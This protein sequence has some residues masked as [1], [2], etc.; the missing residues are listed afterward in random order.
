VGGIFALLEHQ[1]ALYFPAGN[2][3]YK[4][5]YYNYFTEIEEHFVRR[6]GKH[7]YVSPLDWSLIATWKESGVPLHV[8]LRG[9]DIA[10]DV[11]FS[12]SRHGSSKL[13]TLLYCH[14]SVMEEYTRFL[15]SHV[16]ESADAPGAGHATSQE[17]QVDNSDR[18]PQKDT[19][20]QFVSARIAE[21]ER[22]QA[23]QCLGEMGAESTLR[24]LERLRE[25]VADLNSETRVNLED[26]ER[27]LGILEELLISN[28]STQVPQDMMAAWEDE[29]KRELKVYRKKVPRDTYEKIRKNYL[30]GKIHVFFQIRELS[31]I[32]L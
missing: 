22:L 18:E 8:A 4:M 32:Q 7:M 20:V 29:A 30:R 14:D 19:V 31:I 21:I 12:R 2:A 15:E 23:K 1:G 11:W 24:I 9:I 5:N 10:M 25:I 6:R 17:H 13:S 16:G 27:D 28:L 26:L 3:S